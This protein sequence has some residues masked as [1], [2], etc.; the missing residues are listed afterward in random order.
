MEFHM[1]FSTMELAHKYVM[2]Q[3]GIFGSKQYERDNMRADGARYYNGYEIIR[4]ELASAVDFGEHQRFILQVLNQ[5]LERELI[6]PKELHELLVI[7]GCYY[8]QADLRIRW[9]SS[10]NH[11]ETITMEVLLSGGHAEELSF[12]SEIL[13]S[14]CPVDVWQTLNEQKKTSA[15]LTRIAELEDELAN[16]KK[17]IK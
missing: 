6:P 2:D 14:E 10:A 3:H 13:F 9:M 17:S 15:I 12:A 8:P 1:R 7:A 16:L 11:G 5:D 4:V